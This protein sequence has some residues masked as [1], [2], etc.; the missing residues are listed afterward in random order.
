MSSSKSSNHIALLALLSLIPIFVYVIGHGWSSILA[1]YV[2]LGEGPLLDKIAVFIASS[3]LG[4]VAVILAWAV[5]SERARLRQEKTSPY[6]WI[7]YLVFLF[8]LSALGTMNWLFKVSASAEF[9]SETAKDTEDRLSKLD[10]LARGISFP[11]TDAQRQMNDEQKIQ[12]TALITKL[13]GELD[14]VVREAADGQQQERNR[15]VTLMDAFEAEITNEL[16]AGCGEVAKGHIND[17]KEQLGADLNLPSGSC[18]DAK[19]DVVVR[20]YRAA[21]EKA[22]ERRYGNTGV[23]C[24][25]SQQVK[26]IAGQ[27]EQI[28]QVPPTA[29]GEGCPSREA[30]LGD[31]ERVVKEYLKE[32]PDFAPEEVGLISIRDESRKTLGA[33]AEL[34]KGI[35]TNAENLKKENA[36]PVLQDAWSAYRKVYMYLKPLVDASKLAELKLEPSIDNPNIEKIGAIANTI[37]ILVDRYNHFSTYP[38]LLAGILFDLILIAFFSR[39][40]ASRSVKRPPPNEELIDKILGERERDRAEAFTS[41]K[42]P[43]PTEEEIDKIL[44]ERTR[45]RRE[46]L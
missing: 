46:T 40:E 43:Q 37:E 5:A 23:A 44:S 13:K 21:I 19:P 3:V 28:I 16:R 26:D 36:L 11:L 45:A 6:A 18:N 10:S 12:L 42:R 17:I 30:V 25:D 7:A 20:T 31:T 8:A 38:I 1:P 35:Y 2:E 22:L 34:V 9:I 41:V 24:M 39:V 33:Q 14:A 15:I 32:L 29:L 27:I 4:L